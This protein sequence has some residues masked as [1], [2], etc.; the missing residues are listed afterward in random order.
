M[1]SKKEQLL[2]FSFIGLIRVSGEVILEAKTEEISI[3]I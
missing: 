3:H 1:E 2:P